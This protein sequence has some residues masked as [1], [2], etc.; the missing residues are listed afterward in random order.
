MNITI[1]GQHIEVTDALKH[2]VEEKFAKLEKVLQK[3]TQVHVVLHVSKNEHKAEATVNHKGGQLRASA[4][5]EDMYA[6]IQELAEKLERQA[7]KFK[8]K[9]HDHG[10]GREEDQE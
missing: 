6:T 4:V 10:H 2:A 1:S 8:E 3:I 5:T 9:L 7:V